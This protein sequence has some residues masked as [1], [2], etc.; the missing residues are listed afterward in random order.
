[1]NIETK[2]KKISAKFILSIKMY[3]FLC[4]LSQVNLLKIGFKTSIKHDIIIPKFKVTSTLK[5]NEPLKKMGVRSMFDESRADFSPLTPT[6]QEIYVSSVNQKAF[7]EV[8]EL[9]TEA[10]AATSFTL[11]MRTAP[12]M[13]KCDHPFYF[14]LK[15][16]ELGLILF[17]GWITDPTAN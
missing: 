5:L 7:I 13:F 16:N 9:G 14:F 2:L 11:S 15:E 1:M 12:P 8:N 4:R 3:N 17:S 10:A 6:H